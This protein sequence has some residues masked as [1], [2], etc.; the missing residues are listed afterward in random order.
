MM[1]FE[2]LTGDLGGAADAGGAWHLSD[3]FAQAMDYSNAAPI[4]PE[5]VLEARLGAFTGA[6][7]ASA[8]A[9]DC[10]YKLGGAHDDRRVSACAL[11]VGRTSDRAVPE[12]LGCA[13]AVLERAAALGADRA[14]RLA[15]LDCDDAPWQHCRALAGA[16][17]GELLLVVDS[18]ADPLLQ[19]R[20]FAYGREECDRLMRRPPAWILC[21]GDR[22]GRAASEA[23]AARVRDL[24][25][26]LLPAVDGVYL[27]PLLLAAPRTAETL[28]R[29][30]E[31]LVAEL[32]AT[33]AKAGLR[34]AAPGLWLARGRLHR[35]AG[36]PLL[37]R[38][39][40][41]QS[42]G[43]Y[44]GIGPLAVSRIDRVRFRN[45]AEPETYRSGVHA[46]GHGIAQS[47]TPSA[48]EGFVAE[49]LAA[50]ALGEAV[51]LR[52][53]ASR[54]QL[55]RPR[56]LDEL[57]RCFASLSEQGAVSWQGPLTVLVPT[58]ADAHFARIVA[59]L[60]ALREAVGI[61]ALR[62]T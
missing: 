18:S 45:W 36:S 39:L 37:M 24:L 22:A 54:H 15:A 31:E 42:Q 4:P 44:I 40:A 1:I 52:S 60:G 56:L 12:R 26:G 21:F 62:E 13:E 14:P 29:A 20:N 57:K 30:A 59:A 25:R 28:P 53:L 32:A 38:L 2:Q 5:I 23:G 8:L 17:F 11:Y 46:S 34:R 7:A 58:A 33:L 16:D 49:L 35:S 6:R 51:D 41:C 55:A 48:Y 43:D 27:L 10:A 19:Q 9:R 61:I 47:W 50:L 3:R